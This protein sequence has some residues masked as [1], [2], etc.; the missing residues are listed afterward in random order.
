MFHSKI[1]IIIFIRNWS[2]WINSNVN[3]LINWQIINDNIK[4]HVKYLFHGQFEM[5]KIFII[6]K[7]L[8]Y[9]C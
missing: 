9:E 7:C 1:E 6:K 5:L 2:K 4:F 8:Y 3:E